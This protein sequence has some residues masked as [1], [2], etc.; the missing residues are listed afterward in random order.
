MLS[1]ISNLLEGFGKM[2]S[3]FGTN[4]CVFWYIDEPEC[5]KSLIK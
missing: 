4:A 1:L 3:S 5:P 2:A